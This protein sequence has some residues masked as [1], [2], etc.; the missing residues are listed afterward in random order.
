MVSSRIRDIGILGI[1][2]PQSPS[3]VADCRNAGEGSH[4]GLQSFTVSA[5]VLQGISVLCA[6]WV[7][8]DARGRVPQKRCQ[9][10]RFTAHRHESHVASFGMTR[11]DGVHTSPLT[12]PRRHTAKER[13][14]TPTGTCPSK[15]FRSALPTLG[16]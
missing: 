4:H 13:P 12:P 6:V 2:H 5:G 16:L 9:L 1:A 3:C 11:D 10:W 15:P 8:T 14:S 7:S